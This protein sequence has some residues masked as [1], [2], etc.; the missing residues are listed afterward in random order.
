VVPGAT[1]I[2]YVDQIT[3]KTRPQ[4]DFVYVIDHLDHNAYAC[5]QS[6]PSELASKTVRYFDNYL[7]TLRRLVRSI[8]EEH[9]FVW[10][11]SSV[12]DYSDFDFSWHPEQWQATMLHV[13]SSDDEKFGDTFFMHVPSFL[14]RTEHL[15]LLEW[16]DLNFVSS[17]ITRRPMPVIQN[18]NDTHVDAVLQT[19][20][21][22]P[23]ALFTTGASPA[24]IPTVALWREKTKTSCS[25]PSSHAPFG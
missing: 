17:N 15:E 20:W 13:F 5:V 25:F 2:K 22:G 18:C 3:I 24:N 9:E 8:P 16:Y 1:D 19:Q 14:Q 6:L 7:D 11:C 10:I 4:A 21:Q 23:L 12:C